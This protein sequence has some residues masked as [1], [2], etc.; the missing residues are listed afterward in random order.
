MT[1][2]SSA[3]AREVEHALRE[4]VAA[5]LA[6][7]EFAPPA[8]LL[9]DC[10]VICGWVLDDEDHATTHVRCGSPWATRGLLHDATTHI[11]TIEAAMA[12][13][14]VD[15]GFALEFVEDEDDEP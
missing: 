4:A 15:G 2:W 5:V 6:D 1:A 10:F 3:K 7:T 13:A 9:T 14:T 8:G 11:D 12:A